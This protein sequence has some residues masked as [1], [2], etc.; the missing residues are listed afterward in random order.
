MLPGGTS[1]T[2]DTSSRAKHPANGHP[3]RHRLRLG[4]NLT[5]TT[6]GHAGRVPSYASLLTVI[7]TE[8]TSIAILLV[9]Y[10][11]TPALTSL[12]VSI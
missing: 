5:N 8:K 11:D 12:S 10:I 4:T 7:P 2:A 1:S 9:G 3:G 6:A